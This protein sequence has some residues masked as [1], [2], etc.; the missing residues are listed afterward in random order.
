MWDED[1]VSGGRGAA[2]PEGC[3][4]RLKMILMGP[5]YIANPSMLGDQ[6]PSQTKSFYG[7]VG[8]VQHVWAVRLGGEI[9]EKPYEVK[10]RNGPTQAA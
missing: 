4:S 10:Q 8:E 7:A 3:W 6:K 9:R 2:D 1:G 5:A